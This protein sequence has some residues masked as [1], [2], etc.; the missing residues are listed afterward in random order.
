M[1][2]RYVKI[3]VKEVQET[4]ISGMLTEVLEED[5]G[6]VIMHL[7]K[8]AGDLKGG[9]H[10]AFEDCAECGKPR[11][12]AYHNG[13]RRCRSCGY[14]ELEAATQEKREAMKADFHVWRESH[15]AVA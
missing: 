11:M 5:R 14:T 3:H 15:K 12:P 1:P 8:Q 6:L 7:L 13:I 2:R 10:Q 9:L 4:A